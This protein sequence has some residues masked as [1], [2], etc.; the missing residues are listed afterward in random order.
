MRT[1][2]FFLTAI[3]WFTL[4]TGEFASLCAQNTG[5]DIWVEEKES[6]LRQF[7]ST[8]LTYPSVSGHE[9]EAG[10]FFTDQCRQQ[11]LHVKVL[12]EDE[13]RYNFIASLYPLESRKPNIILLS[14]IDVVDAGEPEKWTYPPFSGA[15]INGE[16]WGRGAIDNKAMG[17]M[18]FAALIEFIELSRIRELPFNVS[19]LAV[20]GEETGGANGAGYV[21]DHFFDLL[22]PIVVLGEGGSG[23]SGVISSDPDRFLY[24]IAINHKRALWLRLT[25][26]N[27]SA[28]HGSVPTNENATML[29]VAALDRLNKRKRT[30]FLSD[31][32]KIMFTELSHYEEGFKR[33]A[34]RNIGFMKPFVGGSLRKEPI[35]HALLTNT[36]TLTGIRNPEGANNQVPQEVEAILDCRLLPETDTRV[37]LR[38][39]HK[40]MDNADISIEVIKETVPAMDTRPDVFYAMLVHALKQNHPG[41]EVS[42]ILF[43]ASND[44][45]YF[46]SREVAAYGI[47]PI[48]MTIEMISGVHNVNERI[49]LSAL[50]HGTSVYRDFLAQIFESTL[51]PEGLTQVVRG[52]VLDKVLD[53]PVSDCMVILS[54]DSAAIH[55]S[56]TNLFGEFKMEHVPIGR[57]RMKL[58]AEGYETADIPGIVVRTGREV[59]LKC[60]LDEQ[61][62]DEGSKTRMAKLSALNEM[63]TVSTKTFDFEETGRYPGSRDDPAR[64]VANYPGIRGAD[65]SRNDIIIRGNAPFGLAWRLEDI[66]I[67]NPNH[68]AI[69]GTTGGGVNILNSQ[70]LDRSDF[71]SGAFPAEFGNAIAGVFD[72]QLRTGN[73]EQFEAMGEVGSI[74]TGILAEGPISRKGGS[75]FLI[76]YRHSTLG[77]MDQLIHDRTLDYSQQFGVDAIPQ[78]GD[79]AFKVFFPMRKKGS[80][81]IFGVGGQSDITFLESRRR[82]CSF[83]Y[84]DH[85]QDV[86]FGSQMGIVGVNFT[87]HFSSSSL[88]KITVFSSTQGMHSDRVRIWRDSMS[89]EILR[90]R[91][92]YWNDSGHGNIG[93]SVRLTRKIGAKHTLQSGVTYEYGYYQMNDTLAG[94]QITSSSGNTNIIKAFTQWRYRFSNDLSLT[95]G[96]YGLWF[97]LNQTWAMDPRAGLEWNITRQST[98]SAAVGIHSQLQPLY[99]YFQEMENEDGINGMHNRQMG[100]TRSQH[101]VIGFDRVLTENLHWRLEAYLENITNVPVQV[102]Q[103]SWSM[104]NEGLDFKLSFPGRLQNT[105]TAHNYGLEFT[106][107]RTFNKR[108]YY[109]FTATGFESKYTGSDQVIRNTDAN[110][111]YILNLVIG[112]EFPIGQRHALNIGLRSNLSGGR[113]HTPIDLESSIAEEKTIYIDS[114]AYSLQFRDYFRT[115]LKL[116]YRI[117]RPKITHEMGLDLVNIVPVRF[118]KEEDLPPGCSFFPLSTRNILT[119]LYDPVE[120]RVRTE[121]Q[122]GFLPILY[123]RLHF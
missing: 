120:Q 43:P 45:N 36:V 1:S 60:S 31:A 94:T 2:L 52:T 73:N 115:D 77:L 63:A 98:L 81:S 79:A 29:M 44:N 17:A 41:A 54:N 21:T 6:F 33:V 40:V 9:R 28:G 7:L 70:L 92:E 110:G 25:L 102:N 71:Y 22:N 4:T 78:F 19:L 105:G 32:T 66:D 11:G 117:N 38:E 113:R 82:P 30:L 3:L 97:D 93:A 114:L 109:L 8:Y 68:F 20:S 121:Y 42:P 62:R 67:P 48:P 89:N 107:E 83:S 90:T 112:R 15:V 69:F 119:A 16:V 24:G 37:F 123:Y 122:L 12:S 75:S 101:Y 86:K 72:L 76:S 91:Q 23:V 61:A 56:R 106:L 46:R 95:V 14:H 34:L 26:N 50:L 59:N 47:L 27:V 84:E 64:M 49:S 99:L 96:G 74:S 58:M 39:L 18:Q 87:T 10:L 118:K 80:L 108:Y 65:D 57:Y 85:G 51:T 13:D 103:S 88:A 104:V 53:L 35:V 55:A 100:L 116:T 5:T 111:N